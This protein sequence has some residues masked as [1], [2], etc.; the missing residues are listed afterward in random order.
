MGISGEERTGGVTRRGGGRTFRTGGPASV[1][2]RPPRPLPASRPLAGRAA[3]ALV[4]ALAVL[5]LALAGVA[6]AEE[7]VAPGASGRLYPAARAHHRHGSC[8]PLPPNSPGRDGVRRREDG[9]RIHE[10]S[11]R[12]PFQVGHYGP[13]L[14]GGEA[15]VRVD[16]VGPASRLWV[17]L[18]LAPG[19]P[20]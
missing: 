19:C 10:A 13:W 8:E 9:A 18:P 14:L 12:H 15:F 7:T 6:V 4:G 17:P 20:D 5:P 2:R 16:G 11:A 1:N 3:R